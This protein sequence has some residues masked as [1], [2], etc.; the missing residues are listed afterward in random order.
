VLLPDTEE[1]QEEEERMTSPFTDYNAMIIVGASEVLPAEAV[2][3][4]KL[5]RL[6]EMLERQC[7]RIE[8]LEK[9]NRELRDDNIFKA[10]Q[11]NVL[12]IRLEAYSLMQKHESE[13]TS[14]ANANDSGFTTATNGFDSSRRPFGFDQ[15]AL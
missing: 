1:Q 12:N 7:R 3:D 4:A 14:Q 2:R 6:R 15:L 10:S 8:A 13:K 11:I 5:T 9:E